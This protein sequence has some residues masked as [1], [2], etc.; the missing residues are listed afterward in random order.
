MQT[1]GKIIN[2]SSIINFKI[3]LYVPYILYKVE[4]SFF[5][6]PEYFTLSNSVFVNVY[7]N[8]KR[9]SNR[10]FQNE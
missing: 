3:P 8:S 1:P 4:I 10:N 2:Y 5:Y 6:R 9:I 7:R